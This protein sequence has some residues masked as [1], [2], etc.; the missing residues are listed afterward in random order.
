[1]AKNKKAFLDGELFKETRML[2]ANIIFIDE[3]HG[4]D[5]ISALCNVQLG[6]STIARCMSAVSENLTEQLDWDLA[7]GTW[8]TCSATSP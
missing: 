1:M 8:F 3:K 6:A 5:A 4:S 2:V 7:K